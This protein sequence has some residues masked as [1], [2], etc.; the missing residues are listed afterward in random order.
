MTVFGCLTHT[1]ETRLFTVCIRAHISQEKFSV[2][3]LRKSF[4]RLRLSV[5]GVAL[6][7]LIA[8]LPKVDPWSPSS[9]AMQASFTRK[10]PDPIS[11]LSILRLDADPGLG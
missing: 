11:H 8:F 9:R 6:Y 1:N 5:S 10:A 2:L 3:L 7:D 4:C